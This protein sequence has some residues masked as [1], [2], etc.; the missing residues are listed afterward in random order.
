MGTTPYLRY[1]DHALPP[2]WG[3]QPPY[4]CYVFG[5]LPEGFEHLLVVLQVDVGEHVG[6]HF[7]RL[8]EVHLHALVVRLLLHLCHRTRLDHTDPGG[9]GGGGGGDMGLDDGWM[10]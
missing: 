3:P 10:D 6:G 2:L 5:R 8:A 9:G 1:G 7:V 4:L